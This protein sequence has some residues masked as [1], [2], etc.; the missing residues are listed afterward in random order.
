MIQIPRFF[1]LQF[2]DRQFSRTELTRFSL[3]HLAKLNAYL[4]A[5][6]DTL[7]EILLPTAEIL[8][9]LGESRAS[10][11]IALAIQKS[12]TRA[13]NLAREMIN[14]TI[15]RKS[16]TL[17]GE[18]G[19]TTPAYLEFFP[20]GVSELYQCSQADLPKHL[21]RLVAAA[22]KHFPTLE[23]T[24]SGLLSSWNTASGAAARQ[25]A[26][27]LDDSAELK[28]VL[29]ELRHRLTDNL[30]FLARK[31]LG[32]PHMAAVFFDQSL[33]ENRKKA[34]NEEGEETPSSAS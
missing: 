29:D 33:L 23:D 4:E 34:A 28:T 7:D 24:F 13:K 30:L 16:K 9:T 1:E 31:F 12:R 22:K 2:G 32:Q 20:R 11:E 21:A 26:A 10:E 27:K 14:E 15:A 18:L 8:D 6:P 25:R 17:A 5:H 19:T 3:D